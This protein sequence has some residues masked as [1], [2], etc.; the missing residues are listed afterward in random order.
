MLYLIQMDPIH[1]TPA[2]VDF[3][4]RALDISA[5][6]SSHQAPSALSALTRLVQPSL[7]SNSSILLV[8]LPEILRLSLAGIDSNDQNKTLRTLI[9]YRSLTS[10]VPVGGSVE[11]W[12]RLVTETGD[13]GQDG[14]M[15]VGKDLFASLEKAWKSPDY[16]E[17]I[18]RLPQTSLLRQAPAPDENDKEM[19]DLIY[20][21]AMSAMSNPEVMQQMRE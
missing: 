4:T 21:E 15:R 12:P 16:L 2:F 3:A 20:S 6:H 18:E 17:A 13:I 9:F 1:A 14:T 19:M 5:V 10:W 7:R 11:Q 8:R